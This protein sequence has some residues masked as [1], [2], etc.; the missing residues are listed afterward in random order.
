MNF[1][2]NQNTNSSTTNSLH[3]TSMGRNEVH[4][5]SPARAESPIADSSESFSF[6]LPTGVLING[7]PNSIPTPNK[8]KSL[9]VHDQCEPSPAD[10]L[11]SNGRILPHAYPL[12]LSSRTS[13]VSSS[14]ES[15]SSIPSCRSSSHG[16]SGCDRSSTSYCYKKQCRG[17][18]GEGRAERVKRNGEVSAVQ[19]A[20]RLRGGASRDVK[21]KQL[22]KME[23]GEKPSGFGEKFFKAFGAV[24]RE[25]RAVEP[26]SI[27]SDVIRVKK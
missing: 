1:Q 22:M 2:T 15:S 10:A 5:Q 8:Q 12:S 11:F 16:S 21:L 23:S 9:I 17:D 3:F 4:K 19:S 14:K 27:K 7:V 6:K 26:S 20:R 13:S 25:C 18:T 24:C